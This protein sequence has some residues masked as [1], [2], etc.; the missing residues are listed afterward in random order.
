MVDTC[1]VLLVKGASV[2]ITDN[3]GLTPIL[4]LCTN[5]DDQITCLTMMLEAFKIEVQNG[6]GV[7]GV[8]IR[9]ARRSASSFGNIENWCILIVLQ[10][11]IQ[12]KEITPYTIILLILDR[13]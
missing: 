5:S 1:E 8:A 10:Q 6:S 4:A 9:D 13:K 12:F 2:T 7:N 11:Y 3:Q